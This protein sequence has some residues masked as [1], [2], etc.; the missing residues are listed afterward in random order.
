MKNQWA[1]HQKQLGSKPSILYRIS[2]T[3]FLVSSTREK[4]TTQEMNLSFEIQKNGQ[5]TVNTSTIYVPSEFLPQ[6]VDK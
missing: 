3:E 6:T 4:L 2:D 5:F 1:A